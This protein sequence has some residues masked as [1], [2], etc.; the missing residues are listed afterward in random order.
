MSEA[1]A[2]YKIPV[3][4]DPGMVINDSCTITLMHKAMISDLIGRGL[5]K[6]KSEAYRLG[7]ELLYQQHEQDSADEE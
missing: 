2:T 4:L 1:K 6:S 3:P 5:V 7:I